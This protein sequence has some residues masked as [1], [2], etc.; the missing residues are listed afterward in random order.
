MRREHVSDAAEAPAPEDID[1]EH[2]E[3]Y[4]GPE[5]AV[6]ELDGDKVIY[7]SKFFKKEYKL[8]RIAICGISTDYKSFHWNF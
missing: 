4:G 3:H 7:N 6:E 5:L 1:L 8:K 2:K